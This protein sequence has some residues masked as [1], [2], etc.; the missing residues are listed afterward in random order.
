MRTIGRRLVALLVGAY[1]CGGGQP[2]ELG[3]EDQIAQVN[4]ELELEL[5]GT[6]PDG[7]AL[8]YGFRAAD[9]DLRDR[10]TMTVSPSG[11]GV[12]RWTPLAADV[13]EH[14]FD[15]TVSDGD[16]TTT[17]TI[18][19]DVRSAIGSATMPLFRR[20]LGAGTT[21]DLK[22]K[23]CVELQ[24]EVDD[25]DTPDVALSQ[26]EPIIEGAVLDRIDGRSATWRWC[27]S[28]TQAAETRHT[29]VLAADD[30]DNPK[31]T[32][33]YVVVLRDGNGTS[34]PGYPPVITHV[35]GDQATIVDLA[36]E[37][38]IDDDTGLKDAPLFYYSLT[39]PSNPPDLS[40]MIQLSTRR[41]SGTPQH[42]V[43]AADVP[44]PV[45][46]QPAGTTRSLYY[47]FVADDDDDAAGTCDHATASPVFR[48]VVTSTGVANLPA[49]ESCTSDVQCGAGDLC[50]YMG[51]AGASYCL[52]SCSGGCPAGYTCSSTPVS[53][54][55]GAA[56]E[57]C[58][59]QS[60]SCAMPA[61]AC[62]DDDWE[63]NDTRGDADVNPSI[64]TGQRYEL[65]SCHKSGVRADED[66]FR[67]ELDR[68]SRVTLALE[69][70]PAT[71]LD[72]HLY[73]ADGAL[74]GESTSLAAAEQLMACVAA[75]TYYVRIDGYGS[76]RNQYTLQIDEAPQT[77]SVTCTDDAREDD[78]AAAQ[79]R[80]TTSDF[81]STGN[82]ACPYDDDW[83]RTVISTG[84]RL[85]VDLTFAQSTPQQDLDLH[86][87]KAGVDLTPCD[88]GN[89]GSCTAANGQS[90]DSNEHAEY[91]VPAGCEAGC[92]YFVV[93]RGFAGASAPYAISMAVQ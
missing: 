82:V 79:A 2:P 80:A 45:A 33:T 25:Q 58:V 74:A 39:P 19:I 54:V 89:A 67:I 85:I 72:V 35:P 66:W 40:Q 50:A 46:S 51:S 76:A 49:C 47:V 6:D 43:Y 21:L 15:F 28:K 32:K 91:I 55:D 29:L 38:Q 75:G 65:A 8:D 13:G 61:G 73:A 22:K 12:F 7:D 16:S 81:A 17:V 26:E 77:C 10:A 53:S 83:Y 5:F 63:N 62:V 27:P 1:A 41:V 78:D 20:P 93:V 34:C 44:N 14:A 57:Q 86:L 90:A 84:D 70:G 9:L 4:T 18:T 42:G 56:A 11:A 92:E 87:Y 30:G 68:E 37:A 3:V 64:A 24:I 59:P 31:T 36:I 60:G 69:G 23:N 52:Q 88:V 71:D 48:A